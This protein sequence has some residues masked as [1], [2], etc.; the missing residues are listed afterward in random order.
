LGKTPEFAGLAV[1]FW[2]LLFVRSGVRSLVYI[3][4]ALLIVFLGVP[5]LVATAYIFLVAI[6]MRSVPLAFF[7][8]RMRRTDVL[9]WIP[10]FPIG[11]II[12]QTFRFE[13]F[14]TLGPGATREYV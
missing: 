2:F 9:L 5:A 3:F 11:N 6:V 1:L 10:F 7:L 12:K 8:V 14:G 13:A 4:L